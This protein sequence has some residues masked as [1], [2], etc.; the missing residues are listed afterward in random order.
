[1]AEE[2]KIRMPGMTL[3]LQPL[4]PPGPVDGKRPTEERKKK[5]NGKRDKGDG[6]DEGR[7]EGDGEGGAGIDIMA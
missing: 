2:V 4:S 7:G 6:K 5:G 3:P 1:M